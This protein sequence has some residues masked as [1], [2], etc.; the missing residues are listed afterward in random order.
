MTSIA[1]LIWAFFLIILNWSFKAGDR[2]YIGNSDLLA[3]YLSKHILLKQMENFVESILSKFQSGFRK[4][5]S[6][7]HC[8]LVM[9]EKMRMSI[10]K[11]MFSG[12]LLT[13]LSKAFDCLAHDLLIAK[14][15]AY[16]FD[17]NS[18]HL[19]NVY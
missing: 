12:V 7:Q 10:D 3:F 1:Q 14:L 15:N 19:V 4:G 16:G 2:T 11:K 8:L 13:D 5:F 17:Q 18:L 9:I 6:A